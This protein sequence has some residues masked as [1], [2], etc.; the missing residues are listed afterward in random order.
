MESYSSYCRLQSHVAPFG[1]SS[2]FW[3]RC[4]PSGRWSVY[5][6]PVINDHRMCASSLSDRRV[7]MKYTNSWYN[8]WYVLHIKGRLGWKNILKKFFLNI[9]TKQKNN[10]ENTYINMLNR[11]DNRRWYDTSCLLNS[12]LA[13]LWGKMKDL[14]CS[15]YSSGH[16]AWSRAPAEVTHI[17]GMRTV[18]VDVVSSA[19]EMPRWL[20]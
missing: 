9:A 8:V 18:L 15:N 13:P 12:H 1:F 2:D 16:P 19:G 17:M 6:C 20:S 11:I 10:D 5:I 14:V 7:A 3:S 4:Q